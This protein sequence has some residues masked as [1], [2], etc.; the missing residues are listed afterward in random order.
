VR[1]RAGEALGA[2]ELR[3]D[4]LGGLARGDHEPAADVR[5]GGST[6]G[7]LGVHPPE[8]RGV[9]VPRKHDDLIEAQLRLPCAG[10]ELLRVDE[11]GDV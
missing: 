10:G 4:A 5:G 3:E 7:V 11:R 6:A 2:L 9:V 1:N 8:H